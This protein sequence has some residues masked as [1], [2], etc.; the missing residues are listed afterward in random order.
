MSSDQQLTFEGFQFP[1]QLDTREKLLAL[2]DDPNAGFLPFTDAEKTVGSELLDY[3]GDH[4]QY[5]AGVGNRLQEIFLRQR[6]V[7]GG[8]MANRALISV[9]FEY[10]DFALNAQTQLGAMQGMRAELA[11]DHFNPGVSIAEDFPDGHPGIAPL[12]R[13]TDVLALREEGVQHTVFNPL[14]GVERRT[15]KANS[16]D[17]LQHKVIEDRYTAPELDKDI[18]ERID[19]FSEQTRIGLVRPLLDKAIAS[20]AIR[21]DFWINRLRD[22]RKHGSAWIIGRQILQKIESDAR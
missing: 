2:R 10:G 14:K 22:T 3:L 11:D 13:F 9:A 5:P 18:A 20:E 17:K 7:G 1:A 4:R 15:V 21:L 16:D 6:R 8:A 12:V 19:A